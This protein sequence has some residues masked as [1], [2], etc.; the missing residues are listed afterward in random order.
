[1]GWS[2][3]AT[4]LLCP[5]HQIKIPFPNHFTHSLSGVRVDWSK[6]VPTVPA[7][8]QFKPNSGAG[9]TDAALTAES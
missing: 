9:N 2:S 8:R 5:T 7:S 4:T 1:L 6:K 3:Q